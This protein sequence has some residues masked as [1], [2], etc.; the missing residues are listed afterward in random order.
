MSSR[1]ALIRDLTLLA[2][3]KDGFTLRDAG[4]W[5][6]LL[7]LLALSKDGF[8]LRPSLN[9]DSKKSEN[10]HTM[11]KMKRKTDV[12]PQWSYL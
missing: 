9:F 4:R 8:T 10:S 5:T 2:L 11:G 12:P 3:S 1:N 7:A 6:V